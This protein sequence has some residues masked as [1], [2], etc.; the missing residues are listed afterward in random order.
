MRTCFIALV[1]AQLCAIS[2]GG[3]FLAPF[4]PLMAPKFGIS[5][6][7]VGW[8][9]AVSALCRTIVSIVAGPAATRFGRMRLLVA[10]SLVVGVANIGMGLAPTAV[11]SPSARLSLLLLCRSLMGAGASVASICLLALLTD[12]TPEGERGR[13][14]G[15]AET[16]SSSGWTVGPPIG[17]M[18]FALGGWLLPFAAIGVFPVL[19]VPALLLG[20]RALDAL[21]GSASA[22]GRE[23]HAAGRAPSGGLHVPLP[24]DD[25]RP[26]PAPEP[27]PSC[28]DKTGAVVAAAS[29]STDAVAA[30]AAPPPMSSL[31]LLRLVSSW[32]LYLVASCPGMV[33]TCW[34]VWDLGYTPWMQSEFGMSAEARWRRRCDGRGGGGRVVAAC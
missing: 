19:C 20:K 17:G 25:E 8:I 6:D 9:M 14:V 1:C 11:S 23:Q 34:N 12:I 13:V 33:C 32:E 30:A 29:G 24:S 3:A 18:L 15:I 16:A 2:L 22:D 7:S 10:G 4:L 27:R 31:A 26:G 5:R 21:D 28:A